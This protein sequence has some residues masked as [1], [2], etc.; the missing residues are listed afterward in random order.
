MTDVVAPNPC[1]TWDL[2][3]PTRDSNP[4]DTQNKCTTE[5]RMTDVQDS[6]ANEIE[7]KAIS[8]QNNH[9]MKQRKFR[10]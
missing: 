5:P 10:K 1:I 8:Q 9:L 7:E 4:F 2:S 6:K 3:I